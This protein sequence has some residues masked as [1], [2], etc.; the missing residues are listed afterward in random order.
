MAVES[1]EQ[2]AGEQ[3]VPIFKK[4]LKDS[5][6]KTKENAAIALFRLGYIDVVK[7][8]GKMLMSPDV[9]VKLAAISVV[10]KAGVYINELDRLP[11]ESPL[12]S[13]L[14]TLPIKNAEYIQA[15][16]NNLPTNIILAPKDLPVPNEELY[17]SNIVN[18]FNKEQERKKLA[19]LTKYGTTAEAYIFACEYLK[20]YPNDLKALIYAGGAAFTLKRYAES[21]DYYRK[22]SQL[23]PFNAQTFCSLGMALFKD[24]RTIDSTENLLRAL[25]LKPDYTTAR[26]NLA[27]IYMKLN[28]YTEAV[29]HFEEIL[30]YEK[31][32]AGMLNNLAYAYNKAGKHDK[33]V[34][35]YRRVISI[36]PNDAGAYYNLAV[37]LSRQGR[38]EVAVRLLG[39]ALYTVKETSTGY[40]SLKS[41]MQSLKNI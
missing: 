37:L 5:D 20:K 26:F 31:P 41:L 10:N 1:L 13:K 32:T 34:E 18:E 24:Q 14:D 2:I 25:R 33:S 27:N 9:S 36:N 30:K 7:T 3:A 23:D 19:E 40:N 4:L 11:L 22:A 16:F 29:R 39:R 6:N 28:R 17:P 21:V 38:Q 35:V 15:T 12:R 8:L